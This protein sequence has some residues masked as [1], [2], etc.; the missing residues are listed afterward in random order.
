MIQ[1]NNLS[2]AFSKSFIEFG[3]RNCVTFLPKGDPLQSVS[4]TGNELHEKAMEMACRIL[5]RT[6]FLKHKKRPVLLAMGPGLD[7]VVAFFASLYAGITIAPIPISRN[8]LQQDRIRNI[9]SDCSAEEILCDSS[10]YE[11]LKDFLDDPQFK[12]YHITDPEE[13]Q[14]SN[15]DKLLGFSYKP[16]DPA[17][18]QYTSGSFKKPKGILL[19]HANVLHN[20]PLAGSSWGF[21]EQ[22]IA[23]SWLPHYHDMGLGTILVSL[24]HRSSVVFM[25][26]LAFIQKPV[27]WLQMISDYKVSMSGAPPFAF[28]LCCNRI[29]AEETSGLDLSGWKSAFVGSEIVHKKVMS[30]FQDKFSAVGLPPHALFAC[31]GMAEANIFV[32]GAPITTA[33]EKSELRKGGLIAPCFLNEKVRNSVIIVDFETKK[34]LQ[35][36]EKGE[37]WI[38]SPSLANGY[39]LP[40]N[41]AELQISSAGFGESAEG[42]TGKWFRSGDVGILDD[43]QLYV[44]G[45]HRDT[46]KVNGINVSAADIEWY[47][48]EVNPNLNPGAA[49]AFRTSEVND[50]VACLLMEVYSSVP[51]DIE[52][53]KSQIRA[54][55]LSYF[56]LELEHILI[57]KSGTL[58]RTSSGKIRR[59]AIGQSFDASIYEKKILA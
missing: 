34:R 12:L 20:L 42:S 59:Y 2:E 1:N 7:F 14:I 15:T 50:G 47:A 29:G 45:R 30:S 48:A 22:T 56:S 10:G 18:I 3:T 44:L 8:K 41:E 51:V 17:Y 55:I 26:P 35:N 38:Q 16:G 36:G 31:Y 46:I 24:F 37:I 33:A 39:I 13:E 27:R 5:K 21:T 52:E 43:D 4:L 25:S 49:A 53:V 57:L 40:S 6:N 58:D 54:K 23:G 9:I 28:N 11:A 32:A 19:S